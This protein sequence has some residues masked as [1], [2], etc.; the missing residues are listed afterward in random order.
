MSARQWSVVKAFSCE[1]HFESRPV[2]TS[3][4]PRHGRATAN[5][6]RQGNRAGAGRQAGGNRG[7]RRFP[8]FEQRAA[9]R[10]LERSLAADRSVGVVGE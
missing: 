5:S 3:R 10:R 8:V 6:A 1:G 9:G 7:C 4:L 2:V